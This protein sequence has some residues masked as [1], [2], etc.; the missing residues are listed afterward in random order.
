[1]SSIVV[2]DAGPLHYLALIDCGEIL[3]N[4]FDHVLVPLAVRDELMHPRAPQKVKS[5]I[6]QP[7]PWLELAPV[8]QPQAVRGLHR[9]ETAVLQL[10]LE[11]HASAVLMDDMDGRAAARRL[12]IPTIFTVAILELAAERDLIDLPTM[13][14][15]LQQTS[16]FVSKDVLNAALERDKYRRDKK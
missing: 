6:L 12:G 7:R 10:A 1:M 8:A 11:R 14:S 4:L 16:F 13:I 15:E 9:G 5:W 2:A 3:I